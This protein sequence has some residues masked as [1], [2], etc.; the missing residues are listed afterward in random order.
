M[1]RKNHIFWQCVPSSGKNLV[2][3]HAVLNPGMAGS[4][5]YW[6]HSPEKLSKVGYGSAGNCAA[7][8]RIPPGN[9]SVRS[10]AAGRQPRERIKGSCRC[11]NGRKKCLPVRGNLFIVPARRR[12]A[13][14]WASPVESPLANR[15][16]PSGTV[17]TLPRCIVGNLP[18]CR[19]E[20]W[21]SQS[22]LNGLLFSSLQYDGADQRLRREFSMEDVAYPW[23]IY[24]NK[25]QSNKYS[26][27]W[28]RSLISRLLKNFDF[29]FQWLS[30]WL[31][32]NMI[33]ITLV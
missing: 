33:W 28:N 2:L 12:Q 16:G 9:E 3:H 19:Y 11:V 18:I 29:I 24:L 23:F 32:N 30:I 1:P 21:K 8:K 5:A 26:R 10:T 31:I 27:N 4:L 20:W 17:R 13:A 7:D 6:I 14:A 25:N 15:T 22:C